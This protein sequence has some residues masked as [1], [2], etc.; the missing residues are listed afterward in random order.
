M[1]KIII[2]EM[3]GR[4]RDRALEIAFRHGITENG[5]SPQQV[6]DQMVR[7]LT[8]CHKDGRESK[9]YH[10]WVRCFGD[11]GVQW[12]TG[13]R[14]VAKMLSRLVAIGCQANRPEYDEDGLELAK[15]DHRTMIGHDASPA[16]TTGQSV[17]ALHTQTDAEGES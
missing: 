1:S 15:T 5:E 14:I 16:K 12:D 6:I 3:P 10:N 4:D 7:A 8:G 9:E 11:Y 17:T 13:Q 2:S